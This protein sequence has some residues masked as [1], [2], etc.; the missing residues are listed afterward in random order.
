MTTIQFIPH[1]FNRSSLEVIENANAIISEYQDEG[2]TLSLRQ[3]F[4]QMVS[5]DMIP[6]T[7]RSYK[8][9]GDIV[10]N[11]RNAGLMS[12]S[13]IEDRNR[14]A[15][16]PPAWSNPSE[17]VYA[18]AQQFRVDRWEGQENYVEI[19]V[20]KDALSGVLMPTCS[21]YHVRFTANKGY[22]SSTM[23]FEAGRRINKIATS[24]DSNVQE[25]HIIYAGDHDPSGMDMT[26][27]V[28]DR[29]KLY[30]GFGDDSADEMIHIH[31]VALNMP[32]VE[33]WNPPPNP[34]KQTDS[35][36]DGYVDQ[37][38][39]RKSWELDAVDPK[40][41]RKLVV[42]HIE[43]LIDFEQW[44]VIAAKEE[45]MRKDLRAFADEYEYEDE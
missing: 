18:A 16:L 38:G 2:M 10:S 41:L 32:Q 7:Q 30:S 34:A 36:F 1:N 4:Y 8:R 29:V 13:A 27:D 14:D 28:E 11:A 26:R 40:E 33:K 3:L 22:S 37:Y 6:N 25:F 35:R 42:D 9:V 43:S 21:K 44:S 19:M 31:R 45:R 17:I 39:T 23:L 24:Q 20:E 5:K 15:Y 12:W